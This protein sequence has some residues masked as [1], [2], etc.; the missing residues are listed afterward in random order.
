MSCINALNLSLYTTTNII[1]QH[2]DD[3]GSTS[4]AG[5]CRIFNNG[6][7]LFRN[8]E[9]TLV[10]CEWIEQG[11]T[12]AEITNRRNKNCQ[13]K[14]IGDQ[15]SSSCGKCCTLLHWNNEEDRNEC[16]KWE[17][18]SKLM[19]R[20]IDVP[21]DATTIS[22]FYSVD[23]E[24][25]EDSSVVEEGNL[26]Q[27]ISDHANYIHKENFVGCAELESGQQED[28]QIISTDFKSLTFLN[29]K[30]ASGSV[31]ITYI[32]NNGD[33]DVVE[34]IQESFDDIVGLMASNMDNTMSLKFSLSSEEQTVGNVPD[35]GDATTSD[36]TQHGVIQI[37]REETTE[38]QGIFSS[39]F[40]VILICVA[41][42]VVPIAAFFMHKKRSKSQY[43]DEVMVEV[44]DE[45]AETIVETG[46]GEM[47]PMQ[48]ALTQTNS[49]PII[50]DD[51]DDWVVATV[52][53]K[54][55]QNS[56]EI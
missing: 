26:P 53:P 30:K 2:Y 31:D 35:S 6:K 28:A 50:M 49:F 24:Y 46:R 56:N 17:T 55:K 48:V 15:C 33:V 7:F 54:T 47:S 1:L 18:C 39:V 11:S 27:L 20:E 44:H 36:K 45:E 9:D 34:M 5:E 16:L 32:Q 4:D 23:V 29:D 21:D 13:E 37:D 40:Y 51:S 43:K 25:L 8:H 3:T 12:L 52:S 10:G 38:S 22:L 19:N 42:M 14:R 41:I